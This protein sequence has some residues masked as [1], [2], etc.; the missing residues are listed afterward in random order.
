M[1]AVLRV[2]SVKL[3]TNLPRA[4]TYVLNRGKPLEQR[5]IINY[6]PA[7]ANWEW[8]KSDN[9][10]EQCLGLINTS[11]VTTN[12]V[13]TKPATATFGIRSMQVAY[14]PT[15]SANYNGL[16]D[17]KSGV[18][19][20]YSL[21]GGSTEPVRASVA[22]E[23]LDWSGSINTTARDSS[24][25]AAG[26]IVPAN[27]ALTGF[28]NAAG[29]TLTGFGLTGVTIQSF[30]FSIGFSRAAVM[31]IGSRFPVERP[32][33]DVGASFSCQ[34]Y[35]DGINNS[36]TG[37]AQYNCGNPTFG[38]IGLTMA[39]Q[40]TTNSPCTV[41]MVNP[42]FDTL[43]ISSQVGGFSTFALSFS[44]P[45]GPNPLEITDGSVVTLT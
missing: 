34:G 40:C 16:Y 41:T 14:A 25:Y 36:F 11:N 5:Q 18:L 42:Y 39:P 43:S 17:L 29:L 27:Q 13:D 4:N 35:F 30:S 9:M 22:M 45:I 26:L 12:L 32:L 38:T 6:T 31:Q 37:L 7:A 28:T 8:M 24:N 33:T 2:T 1:A 19:T 44:L 21:Q 15:S 3:D 23:F 20:S 10:V